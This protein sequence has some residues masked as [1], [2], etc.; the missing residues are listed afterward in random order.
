[1]IL[2]KWTLRKLI[3]ALLSAFTLSIIMAM[4]YYQPPRKGYP[5]APDFEGIFQLVFMVSIFVFIIGGIPAS[6]LIESIMRKINFRYR[7]SAYV[8]HP[9]LYIFAG[10]LAGI[11]FARL[12]GI[13]LDGQLIIVPSLI[14]GACFYI[15]SLCMNTM[16]KVFK[17]QGDEE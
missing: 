10:F 5:E 8:L 3:E 6:T 1:M 16:I 4:I 9:V 13:N 7:A 15:V 17:E 12:I 11:L 14:G 2:I